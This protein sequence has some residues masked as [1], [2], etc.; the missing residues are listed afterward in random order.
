MHTRVPPE[1]VGIQQPR[2]VST[3]TYVPNTIAVGR[4]V[5]ALFTL[6]P[7]FPFITFDRYHAR[8]CR[9]LSEHTC[10]DRRIVDVHNDVWDRVRAT[11]GLLWPRSE[12]LCGIYH[13]NFLERLGWR[14]KRGGKLSLLKIPAQRC[15]SFTV[16][17]RKRSRLT[18]QVKLANPSDR[19]A[20]DHARHD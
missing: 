2:V 8:M 19:K 16:N 11:I 4:G 3:C 20:W 6:N 15:G 5:G 17:L 12:I 14:E 1:L 9:T 7:F 10:K 18:R 13:F